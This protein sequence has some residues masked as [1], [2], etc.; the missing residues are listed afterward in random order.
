M[1]QERIRPYFIIHN[2]PGQQEHPCNG[3]VQFIVCP[4]V[5]IA[6]KKDVIKSH[7]YSQF[8]I[9][10]PEKKDR[11]YSKIKKIEA[12]GIQQNNVLKRQMRFACK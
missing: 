9:P 4:E 7:Q 1:D 10:E 12:N 3:L 8:N 2:K 5:S 6:Y 11:S